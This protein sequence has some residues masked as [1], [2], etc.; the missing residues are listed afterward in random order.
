MSKSQW[1]RETFGEDVIEHYSHFVRNE[2]R[3]FY[4][5]VTDWERRRYFERI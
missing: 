4:H 5:S 3:E 2:V 1:A